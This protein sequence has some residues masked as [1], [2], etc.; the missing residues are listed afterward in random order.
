MIDGSI[1]FSSLPFIFAKLTGV[2]HNYVAPIWLR[3]SACYWSWF[4]LN[5]KSLS[6]KETVLK[7]WSIDIWD[8]PR[9]V[10]GVCGVRMIFIIILRCY[11][12]F[13]LSFLQE[14]NVSFPDDI[15]H[16]TSQRLKCKTENRIQLPSV[17]RLI[18]VEPG[19][20]VLRERKGSALLHLLLYVYDFL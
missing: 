11:L 18:T 4:W 9:P 16:V 10:Q 15:W 2:S 20:P 8:F 14:R 19:C 1:C 17:K 3:I 6:L 5:V 12:P 7:L 13:S